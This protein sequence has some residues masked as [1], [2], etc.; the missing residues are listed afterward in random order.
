MTETHKSSLFLEIDTNDIYTNNYI[1]QNLSPLAL[2]PTSHMSNSPIIKRLNTCNDDGR[3]LQLTREMENLNGSIT[4]QCSIHHESEKI[5]SGSSATIYEMS[6]NPNLYVKISNLPYDSYMLSKSNQPGITCETIGDRLNVSINEISNALKYEKLSYAFP[7]NI[8]RI[9]SAERCKKSYNGSPFFANKFIV[10]KVNGATLDKAINVMSEQELI[11]CVMQLVY[12]LSYTNM[13]G[14]FHNDVTCNNVMI[15]YGE[16]NTLTF[17]KLFL[18]D[19]IIHCNFHNARKL[20]IVKLI[21]FSYSEH[22][23]YNTIPQMGNN[24]VIGEPQQI[25]KMIKNRLNR[26]STQLKNSVMFRQIYELFDLISD[27]NPMLKF[28]Y[29]ELEAQISSVGFRT[30]TESEIIDMSISKQFA[31]TTL[32]KCFKDL[33]QTF[34][35]NML[36]GISINIINST[37][38]VIRKKT[39]RRQDLK[40]ISDLSLP[41]IEEKYKRYANKTREILESFYT[42]SI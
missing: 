23:N 6:G 1:G 35:R 21:D 16:H 26:A 5:D 18:F 13:H 8:M 9:E 12:I 27:G 4:K 34:D 29:S 19:N 36:Y 7:Q 32:L 37:L 31:E 3:V 22:I 30:L 25:L 28:K 39:I 24:V 20:P 41:E 15:Y 33:K 17:N 10:E 38:P 2:S 14:Y 42:G 11:C 40:K